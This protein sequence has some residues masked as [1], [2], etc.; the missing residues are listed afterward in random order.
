M[1]LQ[2]IFDQL[3][4]A[5]FSM[6]SIGGQPAGV[7][8]ENNWSNLVNHINLGLTALYS[9]F[10]LK[11]GRITLQLIPN[12]TYYPITSAYAVNS[13]RGRADVRYLLDTPAQP[14]DDDIVK[15]IEVLTDGEIALELN[16]PLADY[17]VY[18]PSA[19]VLR[20]PKG[21]VTGDPATPDDLRTDNLTLVYRAFHPK[22][23][24]PLGFFDPARVD[25]ELP[26]SHLEALLWYVASR[27]HNPVGMGQEFNAGNQFY[28][29]YENA[30]RQLE[31][32]GLQV[33]QGGQSGRFERNGFV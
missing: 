22:V 9:R 2:D 3:S 27:A 8:N 21:M 31:N 23:V 18:T 20:V 24:I 26:Y 1:K 30:C 4:T 33:D 29:K 25:V 7:I 19:A 13:R 10:T 6:I 28:A 12:Q 14:F 17:S 5:E 11:E 16:D 15:I 32:A